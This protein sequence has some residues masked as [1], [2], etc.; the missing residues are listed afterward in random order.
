VDSNKKIFEE[1]LYPGKSDIAHINHYICRSF[2]NW[3]NRVKRG[4]VNFSSQHFTEMHQ[5]RLSEEMCLKQF[6]Q[7][8]ALNY[9]EYIDEYMLKY[10]EILQQS[11]KSI[12]R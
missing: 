4:D 1:K 9:N 3:M 10:R 7:K 5:W 2:K 11:I 12:K 8:I 6:V